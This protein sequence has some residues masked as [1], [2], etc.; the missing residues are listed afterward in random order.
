[1]EI[2]QCIGYLGAFVIGTIMGITGCGG[3]VIAVPVFSYLFLMN[4]YSTTTYS[5]FVVGVSALAGVLLKTKTGKIDWQLTT[6][7]ALPIFITMFVVRKFLLPSIPDELLRISDITVTRDLAIMV[8]FGI[9]LVTAAYFMI[10]DEKVKLSRSSDQKNKLFY[11]LLLS[12]GIG[13][14]TG[15]TGTGGG[16]MIVPVL[17]VFLKLPIK[18]AIVTSLLIIAIKSFIGFIGDIGNIDVD[19]TLLLSFTG[20]SLTG[21]IIGIYSSN[22]IAEKNLK[23]VLDI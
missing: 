16:F 8:L 23:K 12:M 9:L 6:F 1:M 4:M 10:T 13:L 21:M 20:I 11:V 5:L 3:S 7:F 2:L 18:K 15:I 17:V 14:V 22:F 19:W